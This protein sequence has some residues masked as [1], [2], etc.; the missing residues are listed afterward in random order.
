MN[1]HITARKKEK[2]GGSEFFPTRDKYTRA[3]ADSV[4][5]GQAGDFHV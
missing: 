1:Q 2:E 3:A 4:G 5:V